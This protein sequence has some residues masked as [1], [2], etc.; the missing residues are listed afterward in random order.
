MGLMCTI[1]IKYHEEGKKIHTPTAWERQ[2]CQTQKDKVPEESVHR[3]AVGA[4]PDKNARESELVARS[5]GTCPRMHKKIQ[6]HSP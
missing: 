5:I 2:L 4:N 1:I 6:P 3:D